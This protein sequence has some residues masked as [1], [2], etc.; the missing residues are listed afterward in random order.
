MACAQNNKVDSARRA[1]EK[2]LLT[3]GCHGTKEKKVGGGIFVMVDATRMADNYH[4]FW[5]GI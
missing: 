2:T 3:S 1:G 5:T 4:M